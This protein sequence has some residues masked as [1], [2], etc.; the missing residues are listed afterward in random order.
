M[1]Q[2]PFPGPLETHGGQ[3]LQNAAATTALQR[4]GACVQLVSPRR[5]AGAQT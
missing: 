2:P 1:I 4:C 5:T 3:R